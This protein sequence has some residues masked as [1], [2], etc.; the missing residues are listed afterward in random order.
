[1]PLTYQIDAAAGLLLIIGEARLRK[2]IDSRGYVFTE[3]ADAMTWLLA[4]DVE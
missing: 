1:M 3:R 2:S 4:E